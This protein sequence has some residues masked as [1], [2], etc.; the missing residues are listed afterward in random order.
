VKRRF[1]FVFVPMMTLLACS[2]SGGGNPDSG[3]TNNLPVSVHVVPGSDLAMADGTMEHPFPTVYDATAAIVTNA[4]WTGTLVVHEGRHELPD[5]IIVSARAKLEV[6]PGAQFFMGAL[7]SVH[8]QA[9]VNVHGTRDK[10]VLFTWL[11]EGTHWKAF[12]NFEQTSQNNVF[13]YVIFEHGGEAEFGGS[14]MRGALSIKL[15][16]GKITNCEFRFNEGDDGLNIRAS[17]TII[18]NNYFHENFNDALDSD[19]AAATGRVEIR[20]NVFVANGNDGVDL[21][22]KSTAHVHDNLIYGNGDKGVSIGE[23]SMPVVERNLIVGCNTGMGIKDK[24][25]PMISN[26]TIVGCNVGVY[27]YQGVQGMGSGVGTFKNGIIWGSLSADVAITNV[28]EDL[29]QTQFSYSCIQ[30]GTY[31]TDLT[32]QGVTMPIQGTGILSMGAGCDDPM[33]ATTVDIPPPVS[34]V[35]KMFNLGDFH[36][37]SAAGRWDPTTKAFVTDT[38]TSPC[39]D[40]SDPATAFANEVAPNGGR[41]DLGRYGDTAEA[42]KTP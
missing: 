28:N 22:E 36:L 21:G 2:S 34:G 6:L 24:A 42:S 4:S 3:M 33:F 26:N 23:G 40:K 38:A 10:P 25:N 15:A 5:E 27:V 18:E 20:N 1:G 16:G 32:A 7:S 11:V 12:T 17:N 35:G 39:I 13:D 41:A 14:S 19:T 29:T 8:A 30:S 31:R 9:D 37:K